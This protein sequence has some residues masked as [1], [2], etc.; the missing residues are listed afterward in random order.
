MTSAVNAE[1]A[2]KTPA[3]CT[4]A[5]TVHLSVG[6]P[7]SDYC[8]TFK[9]IRLATQNKALFR[10]SSLAFVFP[11][12]HNLRLLKF[13]QNFLHRLRGRVR[14]R[15]LSAPRTQHPRRHRPAQ[16]DEFMTP[17]PTTNR[18]KV[19][20]SQTESTLG[21]GCDNDATATIQRASAYLF[22]VCGT[23]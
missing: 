5:C 7:C 9:T 15:G 13:L 18:L 10:S 12:L 21:S 23:A 8:P 4:P 19:L 3:G 22:G 20:F 17:C 1:G 6:H 11:F 14:T 16:F 2:G